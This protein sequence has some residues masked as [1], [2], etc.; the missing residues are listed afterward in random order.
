MRMNVLCGLVCADRMMANCGGLFDCVRHLVKSDES[1]AINAEKNADKLS[2]VY[3]SHVV[4]AQHTLDETLRK[5]AAALTALRVAKDQG[6]PAAVAR[7]QLGA[8]ACAARVRELRTRI[9][10][11]TKL[12]ESCER[13]VMGLREARQYQSTVGAL[14]A[15]QRQFKSLRMGALM[16]AAEGTMADMGAT[17]EELGDVRNLLSAPAV[18]NAEPVDPEADMRDLEALLAIETAP[19]PPPMLAPPPTAVMGGAKIRHSVNLPTA[20]AYAAALHS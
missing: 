9:E 16:E 11:N 8:R 12:Q 7:A 20:E 5:A 4:E 18:G 15:V 17:N 6:N 3:G 19:P 13:A 1:Y 14:T 2:A 10:T